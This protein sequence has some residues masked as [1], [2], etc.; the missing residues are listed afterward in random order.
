MAYEEVT[1]NISLVAGE[2]LTPFHFVTTTSDKT[3]DL[4]DNDTT[5]ITGIVMEGVA[6]GVVAPVAISGVPMIEL[7]TTLA[8]GVMI[9]AAAG[10]QGTTAGASAGDYIVGPLLAGGDDGDIVPVLLNIQIVGA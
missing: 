3:I 7:A 8:A 9:S 6:S 4:T 2:T 10:G 5:I 1:V